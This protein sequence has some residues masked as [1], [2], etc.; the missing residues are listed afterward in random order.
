[1]QHTTDKNDSLPLLP[2]SPRDASLEPM[3]IVLGPN[4]D[5]AGVLLVLNF[6]H[7]GLG[8]RALC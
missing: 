2:V 6:R 3:G 7:A 8:R 4:T 1:M 5:E